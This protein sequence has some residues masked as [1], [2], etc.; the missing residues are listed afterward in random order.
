MKKLLFVVIFLCLSLFAK[1]IDGIAVIVNKQPI[2]LY[3]IQKVIDATGLSKRDAI[4][5]LI[6]QKLEEEQIKKLGI[7]VDE[8]DVEKALE[9]FAQKKGMDL[10]SL[11]EAIESRGGN[12]EKYK[13]G[14][15]KQ[16]LRKKLYQA[17]SK[18]L[19]NQ[20]SQ[21]DLK[22]YYETHKD[23]F[24]IAKRVKI[25]KYISPSKAVLEQ[26]QSNP[27]Y[28]PSDASLLAKGEETIEMEKVDPKLSFLL[29][30]TPE[31]SFTQILPMGD[32]Y[33]L[34]YVKKKE[35][36][37]TIPFEEA[38]GYILNK[39]ANK[40]EAK[41]IKEYFDKLKAAAHIKIVRLP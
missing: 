29:N 30:Q 1:V 36:K 35:G 33:L 40:T 23:E 9:D 16:L 38:K 18:K 34:I 4:A 21:K 31:G 25:I 13:E 15:K 5:L 27:L 41:S 32:K 3:E 17:L 2:T 19:K 12:W 22:E 24:T 28:N 10:F 39:L 20:L 7:H 14:V 26:I 6:R 11:Q 8:M 37:E